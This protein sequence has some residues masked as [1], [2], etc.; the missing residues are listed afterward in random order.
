LL[1]EV[2]GAAAAVVQGIRSVSTAVIALA[3]RRDQVRHPLTG[4]G[5]VGSHREST[6]HTACTWVSSKWPARVPDGMVQLRCFVGRDGAQDALAMEDKDLV[7]AV[8]AELRSVLGI[9][10]DPGF[11]RLYRW[12]DAMPQYEVGHLDRLGAMEAALTA[13][14]GLVAAGAPY[15]GVGLPDCI[16]QGTR[17][18][19]QALAALA[20]APAGSRQP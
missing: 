6:A 17:A 11:T 7:A 13:T 19:Q 20:L 5:Y 16:A 9:T 3:F 14:P 12:Q 8:I 1:G 2:N 4:H 10:G 18:A 15:R